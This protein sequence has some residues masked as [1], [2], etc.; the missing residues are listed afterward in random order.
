MKRVNAFN[1]NVLFNWQGLR[2]LHQLH[3][4][5]SKK[6]LILKDWRVGLVI[7]VKKNYKQPYLG[8]FLLLIK[9]YY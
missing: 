4:Y 3:L 2:I 5:G 9:I 1:Y 8:S 7:C 6:W